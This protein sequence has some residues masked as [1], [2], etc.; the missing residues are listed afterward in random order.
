MV[1]FSVIWNMYHD[2]VHHAAEQHGYNIL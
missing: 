1:K 2:N